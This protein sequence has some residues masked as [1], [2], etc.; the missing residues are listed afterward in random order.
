MNETPVSTCIEEK[1][2]RRSLPF[3]GVA[4]VFQGGGALGVYQAGRLPGDP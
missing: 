2:V 1:R 4:L 3:D